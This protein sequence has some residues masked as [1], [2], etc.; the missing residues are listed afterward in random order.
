[1]TPLH[2]ILCFKTSLL[3]HFRTKD[4]KS[5]NHLS[6]TLA[7]ALQI[8]ANDRFITLACCCNSFYLCWG[9]CLPICFSKLDVKL[10]S[11]HRPFIILLISPDSLVEPC[12]SKVDV[13]FYFLIPLIC[14]PCKTVCRSNVFSLRHYVLHLI[15]VY[16]YMNSVRLVSSVGLHVLPTSSCVA[17]AF[18]EMLL[19]T[20]PSCIWV[21]IHEYCLRQSV[22]MKLIQ[23]G[24]GQ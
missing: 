2:V 24:R 1:M 18:I 17:F 19:E 8:F 4:V 5:Y 23:S 3:C 6:C 15:C 22:L 14:Q 20:I 21:P 11:V 12:P 16:D 7:W 9:Y 10:H 13:W